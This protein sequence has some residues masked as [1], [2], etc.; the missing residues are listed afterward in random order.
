MKILT[1]LAVAVVSAGTVVAQT[2]TPDTAAVAGAGKTVLG[3]D[4]CLRLALSES[5]TVKVADMDIV[6][7]DDSR[8][9][10]LGN[11]LPTVAFG[12]TYSRMLAKQVAYMNLGDMPGMGGGDSDA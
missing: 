4:D 6:R 5:P 2:A 1:L 9:E 8:K 11:I 7:V 3:L 12:G 10:T